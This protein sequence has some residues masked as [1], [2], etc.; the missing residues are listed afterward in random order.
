MPFFNSLAHTF[1]PMNVSVDPRSGFCF[2]VQRAIRIAEG[3]LAAGRP[4]L[5]L[6]E[7]VHNPVQ[8]DKL[9]AMGMQQVSLSD[10][11]SLQGK[12]V[13][14]RAHGEPPETY[15][16]AE[17]YQISLIDATCP[18]VSVLQKNIRKKVEASD[19]QRVQTVIFGKPG[20][21]E[22]LGLLGNAGGTGI[23]VQS[24]GDLA[25]IDF[26][27]PVRLFSQTTMDGNH[28][29][30]MISLIEQ[31]MLAAG[32]I[33]LE[34]HGKTCPHVSGRAET[35]RDFASAHDVIV[36]VTGKDSANGKY[37]FSEC[38]S[39]NKRSYTVST[40]DEIHP[41]WFEHAESVG[42]TGATSAPAWLLEQVAGSIREKFN[43]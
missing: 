22:V 6:G 27:R 2:G 11:P 33:D 26:A 21:A 12:T 20:H 31:R 42:I 24:E 32:N 35:V 19:P 34:V 4:L 38:V 37:L 39:V 17:Q 9:F 41:A 16:Q 30:A 13:F 10:F 29:R 15:R 1:E 40:A 18:I 7:M 36:F 14:L 43:D 23:V 5:C 8:M 25:T 28:Y 3:E